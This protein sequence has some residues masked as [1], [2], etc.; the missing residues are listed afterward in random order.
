MKDVVRDDSPLSKALGR[1]KLHNLRTFDLK[2]Q[3]TVAISRG[4]RSPEIWP[5][6]VGTR[7]GF[8]EGQV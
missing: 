6:E 2:L 3:N 7:G 8:E 4:D 5:S 1:N